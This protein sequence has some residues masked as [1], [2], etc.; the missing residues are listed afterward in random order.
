MVIS[1][2][3]RVLYVLVAVI[4]AFLLTR[5]FVAGPGYTDV[6]Y[7]LNA[8]NR[9]V[10]G[11]GLT[12]PYYWTY[13]GATDALPAPSHLYWMP[14]TSLTAAAGMWLF[15]APGDYAAA[16]FFFSLMFA[17]VVLV[18][19]WLGGHLGGTR[20]H[21]WVAGLL[22]LFS[23]FF[24]RFW[25]AIDTFAPFAIV[26]ALCL[27]FLGLSHQSGV[28]Q[29]RR[30]VYAALG[31][32]F[33]GAA[34]LARADGLL[35]VLV[36][37]AVILWMSLFDRSGKRLSMSML[38]TGGIVTT[39]A[40][41]LVM[42]PWFVRN[43]GLIGAPMPLGGTQTIWFTSYDDLFNYPPDSSPA[44]LFANGVGG[45]IASRWLALTNNLGTF[46]AVEGLIVMTPLMLAGLWQRRRER[47]LQPFWIYAV[48]LH[49]A[50]T[51]AFPFPGYRGGLLHSAAALIPFWA[52]LGVVGLDDAVMWMARRRRRWNVSAAKWVFSV[53][54]VGV[55]VL[56]SLMISLPNRVSPQTASPLHTALHDTLPTDARVMINDPAQLYY[57]TGLGGVVLPNESPDVIVEI[58]RKYGVRYLVVE[59]IATDGQSSVALTE[60]LQSLLITPPNFLIEQPFNVPNARLYEIRY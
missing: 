43:Q 3:E 14:L 16:Q 9:L 15:N 45:F 36:A 28:T 59:G 47:F 22:T 23:G 58:A 30:L 6:F 27:V 20:R 4:G 1:N 21:T 32:A 19:F 33:A 51:F 39:V 57:F 2:R 31:G 26:G 52:A 55:A 40:Y 13:I 54:L 41:I 11:Q 10:T 49:L 50:M 44:T 34:H 8:A 37:W 18:G 17:G 25:G 42:L 53:G 24:V 12:D 56:L 60:Q 5:L 48:G 38:I 46:V 7:H 35:F 29:P